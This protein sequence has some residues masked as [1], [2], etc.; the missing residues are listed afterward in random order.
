MDRPADHAT[1]IVGCALIEAPSERTARGSVRSG[2]WAGLSIRA[3]PWTGASPRVVFEI[4]TRMFGLDAIPD[5]P[6]DLRTSA[7]IERS[8]VQ[9]M[10]GYAAFYRHGEERVA[11]Y[12]LSPIV[13]DRWAR[14]GPATG[15]TNEGRAIARLSLGQASVLAV[16]EPGSCFESIERHV[17]SVAKTFTAMAPHSAPRP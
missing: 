2:L 6:P 10:S 12:A 16:G 8:L 7:Q 17:R 5:A 11:V 4:R 3:N 15:G 1:G 14:P 13:G 9:G